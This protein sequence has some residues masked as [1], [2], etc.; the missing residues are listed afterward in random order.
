MHQRFTVSAA[1][2]G[3]V[4]GVCVGG[5]VSRCACA[6]AV[7]FWCACECDVLGCWERHAAG[8]RT[9][10]AGGVDAGA[11]ACGRVEGVPEGQ[12]AFQAQSL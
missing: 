12:E 7:D 6:A 3:A 1:G 8:S 4:A 9:F 11:E 2:P 5:C 10:E